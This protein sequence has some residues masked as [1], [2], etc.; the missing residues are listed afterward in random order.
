MATLAG[1]VAPVM[2]ARYNLSAD[3]LFDSGSARLK[4]A[5]SAALTD[6]L[7]QMRSS[8]ATPQIQVEG[9]TDSVGSDAAN[10][11]LSLRRAEAV[12]AWL[13]NA[14]VPPGV[15]T[16]EGFGRRQP[17]ASNATPG[18]RAQNRRVELVA[19]PGSYAMPA[20]YVVPGP[21]AVPGPYYE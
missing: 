1:C 21:F 13:I 17:V 19:T 4:P 9:H 7:A 18:G 8:Y 10:E 11:V 16:V 12:R 20:P 5:A 15:I 3:V 6:T 2:P 14:G